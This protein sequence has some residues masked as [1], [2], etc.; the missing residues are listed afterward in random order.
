MT[1]RL[2]ESDL[3]TAS[4]RLNAA[5]ALLHICVEESVRGKVIVDGG[6]KT[7]I[8][9]STNTTLE[10]ELRRYCCHAI[11]KILVT[12]NSTVLSSHT[13]LDAIKPLLYLCN[14]DNYSYLEHF[15][16][17]LSLTNL[18]SVS[19][20]EVNSL[21]LHKG[22]KIIHFL[23]LS[24]NDAVQRAATELICNISYNQA[25]IDMFKEHPEYIKLIL[26]Q[27]E[28]WTTSAGS[29]EN[30]GS[31]TEVETTATVAN[32]ASSNMDT[33]S[34][35]SQDEKYLTCRAAAGAVATLTGSDEDLCK[36]MI[37]NKL[38]KT[39]VCLFGSSKYELIHRALVI[40]DTSLSV[41]ADIIRE[42][43]DNVFGDLYNENV[44]NFR[45]IEAVINAC[46]NTIKMKTDIDMRTVHQ[47]EGLSE[48][49][50]NVLKKYN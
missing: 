13:R 6:L 41:G 46:L 28:V 34:G 36:L 39:L 7:C 19:E 32:T 40:L 31:I 2:L 9:I 11:A 15:E 4:T 43:K 30:E 38:I 21:V 17:L 10:P 27:C 48:P 23:T 25:T 42:G 8:T 3:S 14:E 49:I 24:E 29:D 50:L 44:N 37:S 16:S 35:P 33:T 12:T 22:L 47:L 1:T 26:L 5:K 20:D 45:Y 18:T